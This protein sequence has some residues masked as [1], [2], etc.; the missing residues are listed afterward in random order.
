MPHVSN[1]YAYRKGYDAAGAGL[2][3]DDNP[4]KSDGAGG[5][6]LVWRQGFTDRTQGKPMA[7][8]QR[9]PLPYATILP[10]EFNKMSHDT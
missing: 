8:K 6:A 2:S 3:L 4:Y 7:R 9:K 5:Y 1:S 10:S